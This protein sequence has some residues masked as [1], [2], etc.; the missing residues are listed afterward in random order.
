[1][2]ELNEQQAQDLGDSKKAHR[3]KSGFWFGIIIL[4]IV[5][6]LAGFGFYL[7]QGLR[8][9]QEDLGGAVKNQVS[10]QI[11]DSQTQ[12]IEIRT[13]IERIS[14]KVDSK[15]EHFTKAIEDINALH[16]EQLNSTRKELT[17][18]IEKIQRQLGK[19]RGDWLIADA[20]YLLS[21]ANERLQLIGDVHTTLEALD[22]ADQ[23]LKESGDTGV[24]KIREKIADEISLVK[25]INVIDTVGIYVG[26]QALQEHVD[27]LTLLLPF[28]G[29]TVEAPEKPKNT[30][31]KTET[32]KE[33]TGLL[34][35]IGVKHSTQAIEGILSPE[36]A[37]F[38]HEQLRVKLEMV[39]V[40]LVQHNDK[41]YQSALADAKAWLDKHFAKNDASNNFTQELEKFTAVEIRSQFPDISL[42][43]KMLKDISKLRIETDKAQQVTEEPKKPVVEE[44]KPEKTELQKPVEEIK[45]TEK[46]E[47]KEP[48]ENKTQ[49]EKAEPKKTEDTVKPTQTA[50]AIKK[51]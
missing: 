42:S 3:S 35:F 17:E 49:A 25:N 7:F 20:E 6:G 2:T 31:Q 13:Q 45:A 27:D 36:E 5:I 22:A 34:D 1:V 43:L 51:K 10:K 11:S 30:E 21:V 4:L 28:A 26:I 9:K 16:K 15:D 47:S 41:L 39:K 44:L 50:P 29:K 40:T 14:N 37:K 33:S 48:V 8:D 32:T 24:F 38:I 46:P 23:R 18:S 19:T 12:I